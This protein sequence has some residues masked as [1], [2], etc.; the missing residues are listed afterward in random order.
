MAIQQK[1]YNKR[2]V[3]LLYAVSIGMTRKVAGPY[4]PATGKFMVL[5]RER[6]SLYL[7]CSLSLFQEWPKSSCCRPQA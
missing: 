4:G 3:P 1:R 6:F 7:R 2:T 5:N